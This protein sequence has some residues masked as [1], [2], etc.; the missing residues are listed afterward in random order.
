MMQH[1]VLNM[2]WSCHF[3]V[4]IHIFSINSQ[5]NSSLNIYN[6]SL[7]WYLYHI[8]ILLP[9]LYSN[10]TNFPSQYIYEFRKVKIDL[11]VGQST[12]CHP[13]YTIIVFRTV[14]ILYRILIVYSFNT[15]TR[16]ARFKPAK[17]DKVEWKQR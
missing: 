6:V 7:L 11:K 10:W 4:S 14:K 13:L 1:C 3:C 8:L 12:S 9:K 5:I 17:S 15:M 2:K 16:I